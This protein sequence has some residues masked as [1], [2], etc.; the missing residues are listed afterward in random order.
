[1]SM[2]S[3]LEK[4]R[5]TLWTGVV[6][7]DM[8]GPE[9]FLKDEWYLDGEK[10]RKGKRGRICGWSPE[11]GT[12]LQVVRRPAWQEQK[13]LPGVG[14]WWWWMVE[15]EAGGRSRGQMG[16]LCRHQETWMTSWTL[17]LVLGKLCLTVPNTSRRQRRRQSCRKSL[18]AQ[19]LLLLKCTSRHFAKAYGPPMSLL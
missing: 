14:W 12:F 5:Q 10:W 7:N 8:I 15:T 9:L 2:T 1:M 3:W 17:F 11:F 6:R 13:S 4:E 16:E 18:I 19:I